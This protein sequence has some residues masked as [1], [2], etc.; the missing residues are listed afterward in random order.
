MSSGKRSPITEGAGFVKKGDELKV[1]DP[2][3]TLYESVLRRFEVLEAAKYTSVGESLEERVDSAITK[4]LKG[5]ENLLKGG[6]TFNEFKKRLLKWNA[7]PRLI[8]AEEWKTYEE[9][10]GGDACR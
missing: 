3:I 2:E 5:E 7:S 6:E 1:L 9:K 10:G 4:T 8:S